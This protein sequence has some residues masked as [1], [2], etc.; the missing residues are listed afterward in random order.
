MNGVICD[1][2]VNTDRTAP[3][4]PPSLPPISF[5]HVMECFFFLLFSMNGCAVDPDGGPDVNQTL[6]RWRYP[7]VPCTSKTV[8]PSPVFRI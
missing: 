1:G 4:F 5:F 2:A 3:F 8:P 6:I 7:L